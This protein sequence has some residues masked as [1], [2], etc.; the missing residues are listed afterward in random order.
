VTTLDSHTQLS[1]VWPSSPAV[2]GEHSTPTATT[3]ATFPVG[4]RPR[5]GRTRNDPRAHLELYRSSMDERGLAASTIEVAA[6][7]R[8]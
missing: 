6:G 1:A 8:S 3:F 4:S 7:M 2:S 5:P